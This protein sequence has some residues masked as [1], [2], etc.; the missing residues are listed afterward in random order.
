MLPSTEKA[1]VCGKMVKLRV[2]AHL[3]LAAP[4]QKL[5]QGRPVVSLI[6]TARLNGLDPFPERFNGTVKLA[7]GCLP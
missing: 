5:A 1:A 4:G 2:I 6:H 7:P 3:P